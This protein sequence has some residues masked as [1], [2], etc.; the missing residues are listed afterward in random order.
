MSM[1]PSRWRSFLLWNHGSVME[2]TL[3][4]SRARQ[5]AS[6]TRQ[7]IGALPE[8]QQMSGRSRCA[9]STRVS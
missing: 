9:W 3:T 2:V 7:E 6:G 5:H 4:T 8:F 1:V